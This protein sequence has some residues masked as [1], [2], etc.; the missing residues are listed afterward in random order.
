M[1][2]IVLFRFMAAAVLLCTFAMPRLQAQTANHS[3]LASGP[4]WKIGVTADGI[5]RLSPTDI[6]S[7][8][9]CK[10]ADIAMFGHPGGV[11]DLNNSTPR[12]DDLAETAIE[13][14]DANAN[15]IMDQDDYILFYAAG[16]NR[17]TYN[18]SLDMYQLQT[19]PYDTANYLFLTLQVGSHLRI[20]Q[21]DAQQAS[22]E[23]IT[24]CHTLLH[25]EK[26]L[27]NTHRTG[28]IWVGEKFFA[29]N[30]QHSVALH[31]HATPSAMKVGYALA[32]ISQQSSNFTATINGTSFSHPFNSSNRYSTFVQ[33]IEPNGTDINAV[34]A[35]RYSENLAE[36]YLDYVE[37]DA[38]TPI[39]MDGETSFFYCDALD[40]EVHPYNV[41]STSADTRIWDVTDYNHVADMHCSRSGSTLTFT[42]PTN[43]RHLFVAFQPSAAL[44]P[45]TVLPLANQDLHGS[46][47]PDFVIVCHPDLR[48][49]AQRLANLHSIMDD[50]EVLVASQNEVFNEFSGGQRDPMAVR[51]LLRL[52]RNRSLND[53]SLRCPKHLLLFGKGTYDNRNLL[54][55]NITDVVT[56]EPL[57]SFD[58][59]GS[60]SIAT[61]DIF[62]FLDDNETGSV[63]ESLDISVGR[64]PAKDADEAARLVDKIERY[65]MRAD[66]LDDNIRGDWRNTITLLAD[67]AD[68]DKPYDT[69]FTWSSE[70]TARQINSTYPHFTVEKIYAD[71]YVQQSGADGSYYPDVNNALKKRLDYGCL[72][73]NYIGHGSS[74][75]I[76]TERFMMKSDISGYANTL[77]L[78]FFITSTCTFGRFDDPAETCG[79]EEFLLAHGAGIG[80]IAA[81]RPISHIQSVNTAMIMQ[82]LDP[83]HTIGEGIRTAKNQRITTQALTLVGD[84]ALTLSFPKHRVVVTS[85]NGRPVDPARY[86]TALVLSTVTVEGEIRDL[87]GN[88]VSDFDGRIFPEVY[89]RERLSRTLANDNEGCAVGFTQ[90]NSLLYR[91]SVAVSGGRFSYHFIVP[92]DVAYAFDLCRM[93][94]YAKSATEDAS[95]VYQNLMLGGFDPDAL[96]DDVR[97]SLRLFINDTNFRNGAVTDPNPTLLVLL[98]DSLGINSVGSGLG[99]DITAILDGNPN[100]IVVLNDF[101]ET[102]I[103]ND[104]NGTIRYLYSSL[105]SGRHTITVKA[106]NIFNYSASAE[107]SFVVKNADTA[108]AQL[109]AMPNPASDHVCIRLEMNRA[110]TLESARLEI[111]DLQGRRIVDASPAINANSYVAGPVCWDLTYPDGSHARPGIYLA[112]F[113]AIDNNGDKIVQNGKIVVK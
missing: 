80:C 103:N 77:Q 108:F 109:H 3:V 72:L 101:Y 87:D 34:F 70:V 21:A 42:S 44:Q 41:A 86:D 99:H 36:G 40:S 51:Q 93:A 20:A 6:A 75:Y 2:R 78:P 13:V 9:G 66:L 4:W 90:Q 15:G 74:Q 105:P 16:P 106:W 10:T 1:K 12:P 84:P 46:T 5:Y 110:T 104:L 49:Q 17:W 83:N 97:P 62:T 25:Y 43:Q 11:M 107:V 45:A 85:I 7:L 91:G 68:P 89:D 95:G 63:Y 47:Q 100:N 28:Q 50:M 65:M 59:D 81:S 39:M 53:T 52:F 98:H 71:A 113:T 18:S 92:R 31:L 82:C 79:A 64:L 67:D 33:S 56:Y 102:D 54:K 24:T 96:V 69:S 61:D 94:H 73:L 29:S 60:H 55:H 14:H 48:S 58:D 19:H 88:L 38:T 30:N 26:E 8:Q 23:A 27:L 111:F 76:G 32:S 57:A 37:V 22:G 35:Y 112:R